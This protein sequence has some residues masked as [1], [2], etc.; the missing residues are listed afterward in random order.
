MNDLRDS[1]RLTV[2]G[3]DH[4]LCNVVI[5][6]LAGEPCRPPAKARD[7]LSQLIHPEHSLCH[8]NVKGKPVLYL[9]AWPSWLNKG[10]KRHITVFH[11]VFYAKEAIQLPCSTCK[12]CNQPITSTI[13]HHALYEC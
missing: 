7:I 11:D 8:I 2:T 3:L 6:C 4:L 12:T 13:W 9:Q 5:Y 1:N 10:Y